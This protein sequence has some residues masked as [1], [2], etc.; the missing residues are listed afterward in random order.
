MQ[1]LNASVRRVIC[2]YQNGV[3]QYLSGQFEI[4]K[5]IITQNILSFGL[6]P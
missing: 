5:A 6:V 2:T 4:S 3:S 1:V